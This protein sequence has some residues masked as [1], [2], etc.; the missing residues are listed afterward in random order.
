MSISH[1][2]IQPHAG[3]E[4]VWKT[5]QDGGCKG[6]NAIACNGHMDGHPTKLSREQQMKVLLLLLFLKKKQTG[7]VKGQTCIKGAPQRAYIPKEEAASPSMSTESTF[8][9]ASIAASEK[10]EVRCYNVSG[11]FVNTDMD[12]HVLMVLKGELAEMMIQIAP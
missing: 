9:T 2:P 1:D 4:E 8:I 6:A 11:A 7:D 12:E 10:R 5:R 3:L